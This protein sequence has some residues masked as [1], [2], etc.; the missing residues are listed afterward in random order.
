MTAPLFFFIAGFLIIY[1]LKGTGNAQQLNRRVLKIILRGLVLVAIGYILRLNYGAIVGF[2]DLGEPGFRYFLSTHVLHIIGLSIILISA[3][4][5]LLLRLQKKVHN[6][7]TLLLLTFGAVSFYAEYLLPLL[8]SA[9]SLP[10]FIAN[11]LYKGEGSVFVLFPWIAYAFFGGAFSSFVFPNSRILGP[12][13]ITPGI[14]L[15]LSGYITNTISYEGLSYLTAYGWR[16]VWLGWAMVLFGFFSFLKRYVTLPTV[17][18]DIGKNTLS[19][20]VIHELLLFGSI[21]GIGIAK[22]YKDSLDWTNSLALALAVS[23]MTVL[24]SLIYRK[25][26]TLWK[27]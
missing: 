4:A 5:F 14:V 23:V 19:I 1:L 7:L 8:V 11:W 9:N 2:G 16:Y 6:T 26:R 22:V 24:F 21:S 17:L 18:L 3:I 12:A 25:I 27:L 15:I 13:A 10:L 20:F